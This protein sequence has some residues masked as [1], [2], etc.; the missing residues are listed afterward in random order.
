M[1]RQLKC[2]MLAAVCFTIF[3][4]CAESVKEPIVW[5]FGL[6]EIE[7]SVQDI[8]AQEF[9][10]R[11]EEKSEGSVLVD[12]YSYG[13]L[14]ESEDLTALT[15]LGTLQLTHASVGIIGNLVPEMQVFNI[16]YIY[17]H[18]DALNQ[19]VIASNPVVYDVIGNALSDQGLHLITLYLE[20]DMVW[21]TNW[22]VVSPDDFKGFRMRV[23]NSPLLIESFRLYGADTQILPYSQVYGALL[24]RIIDGQ[25]NPVFSIEEMKFYEV[26]DYMIWPGGHKFTTSVIANQQWYLSLSPA[27]KSLL[28]ETVNELTRYIFEQQLALNKAQLTKI[29]F[30]KPHMTFITLTRNQQNAFKKLASPLR[31]RYIELT[32]KQG[33]RLLNA[34]D[35]AFGHKQQ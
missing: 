25:T 8:Y 33:E 26:T 10:R 9:K 21:S 31:E 6:E 29:K 11:I 23:M 5:R 14:G 15:A 2:A 16:P 19:S 20:G 28:R 13:M 18:D 12:I 34:L 24:T 27:H 3:S 35:D 30:F 1:I 32:G 17:S 7:G 4:V 22:E